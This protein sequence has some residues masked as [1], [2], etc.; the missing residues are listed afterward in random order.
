[1]N[2]PPSS[3][4]YESGE[5]ATR[6][7]RAPNPERDLELLRRMAGGDESALGELYDQ[8]VTL[9]H[10][11]AMHLLR[12]AREAEEV[13]EEAFWQAWRQAE[14]YDAS[15]G[16]VSTWLTTIVRSRALDRLRARRRVREEPLSQLEMS[17]AEQRSPDATDPLT[18][19]ELAERR[20][21]V[22][23]ALVSLPAEQ[24]QV[25]ELA[26]FG[27]LSQSEIAERVGLPLGTV[28][29]RARL[30]LEKLRDRLRVLQDEVSGGRT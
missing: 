22:R 19:A 17:D 21:L 18:G 20:V 28:K 10:S 4:S 16:S 24:R 6:A 1:M 15:R 30:A 2:P 23:A 14:R 13:V 25:L 8:W 9:V 11:V 5:R 12:D 29:T 3:A 7:V 26:Y 27:G